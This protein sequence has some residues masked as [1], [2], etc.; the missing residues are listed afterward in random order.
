MA[1]TIRHH[2][3]VGA[4]SSATFAVRRVPTRRMPAPTDPDAKL[5]RKGAGMEAK[6]AF[7]GPVL[8]ENRWGLIVDACLTPASGHAERIAALSRTLIAPSL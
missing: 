8:M 6:L 1:R 5:Y 3:R 4:T 7:L 2:R